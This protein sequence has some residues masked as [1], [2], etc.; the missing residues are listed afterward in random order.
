[1]SRGGELN[2]F[3][4]SGCLI[5]GTI[6]FQDTLRVDGKV[7][8]RLESRNDLVVGDRGVGVGEVCVGTL[9][10]SGTIRGKVKAEKKIVIHRGGRLLSD[11]TTP[12]LVIE[13]GGVFEGSCDMEGNK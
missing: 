3:L 9:Y 13:E 1:M 11:I 5:V 12:S 8:G 6:R 4:D 2:G 7:Q 10:V